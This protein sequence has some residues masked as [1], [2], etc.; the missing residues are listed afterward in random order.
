MTTD[1]I[2]ARIGGRDITFKIDRADLR[3]F[4][5]RFGPAFSLY[6]RIVRGDWTVRDLTNVLRFA[7]GPRPDPKEWTDEWRMRQALTEIHGA[8]AD[9][10]DNTLA[11]NPPAI[12]APLA[13]NVIGAALFGI[14]ETEA[15]FSDEQPVAVE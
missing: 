6:S 13:A 10:L 2:T 11:K 14:D 4:E 5:G 15:T 7:A 12:Y 9:F 1:A 8:P 3:I